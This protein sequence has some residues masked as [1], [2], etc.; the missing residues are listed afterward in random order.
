M[1]WVKSSVVCFL[2]YLI[3]GFMEIFVGVGM[4]LNG[5]RFSIVWKIMLKI[6]SVRSSVGI[7]MFYLWVC[8]RVIILFSL[9]VF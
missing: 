8:W 3:I 5:L 9:K 6:I 4:M 1:C 2:L 7:V